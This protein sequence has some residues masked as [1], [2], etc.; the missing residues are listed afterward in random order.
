MHGGCALFLETERPLSIDGVPHFCNMGEGC[1]T[2][3]KMAPIF[4][5]HACPLIDYKV[6]DKKSVEPKKPP[7]LTVQLY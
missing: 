5:S 7:P 2:T 6:A 3:K 1:G 4:L